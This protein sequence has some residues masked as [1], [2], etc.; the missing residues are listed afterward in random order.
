MQ[1][2]LVSGPQTLGWIQKLNVMEQCRHGVLV[3]GCTYRE[4]RKLFGSGF[5]ARRCSLPFFNHNNKAYFN[6]DHKQWNLCKWISHEPNL[7][8]LSA[9]PHPAATAACVIKAGRQGQ[10]GHRLACNVH[11]LQSQPFFSFLEHCPD[12]CETLS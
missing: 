4:T 7:A 5:A 2:F 12:G 3:G 9:P 10:R 8:L 6:Q 11:D 1:L